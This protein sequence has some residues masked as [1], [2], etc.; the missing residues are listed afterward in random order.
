MLKL[1]K[2]ADTLEALAN[3]KNPLEL[4]YKGKIAQD[5]VKELG[6]DSHIRLEDLANYK[7]KIVEHPPIACELDFEGYFE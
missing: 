7:T 5:I 1:E 6:P 2:Y 3:S 4:F